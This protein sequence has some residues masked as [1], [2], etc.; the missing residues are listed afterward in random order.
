MGRRGG[1]P[2]ANLQRID[3][4]Y[5]SL[6]F[7]LSFEEESAL[8]TT[9]SRRKLA[10]GRAKRDTVVNVRIAKPT[11]ELIDSAAEAM[12]KSRSEF[13]IESAQKSAMNVLLDQ[14]FFA[15]DAE[16]FQSFVAVLDSPPAPNRK[17]KAL[18]ASK[19]PWES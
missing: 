13:I 4:V 2:E 5:T 11:R 17:L 1:L 15:L 9:T 12:G 3:I 18:L 7:I 6:I 8:A 16:R 19:A 10:P 14:T